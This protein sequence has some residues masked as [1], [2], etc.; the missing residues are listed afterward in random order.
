MGQTQSTV[1]YQKIVSDSFSEKLNQIVT[2]NVQNVQGNVDVLQNINLNFGKDAEITNCSINIIQQATVNQKLASFLRATQEADIKNML[3]Q[4]V[5]NSLDV[6]QNQKSPAFTLVPYSQ[7]NAQNYQIMATRLTNITK[8]IIQN[9]SF[10]TCIASVDVNQNV[11]F[12]FNGKITCTSPDQAFNFTQKVIIDSIVE[13][14]ISS[15]VNTL[16]ENTEM[17][18]IVSK[19]KADQKQTITLSGLIMIIALIIVALIVIGVLYKM[20]K[21]P[22][23]NVGKM[24][25]GF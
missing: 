14:S 15:V 22:P 20:F 24:S 11:I 6:S 21:S 8:N 3:T 9:L 16:F 18:D 5:Q 2:Q 1:N 10:N 25:M 4:A 12:N 17:M 23:K 13:C 7:Q 19:A